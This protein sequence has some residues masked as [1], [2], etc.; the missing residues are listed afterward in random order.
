MKAE[1]LRSAATAETARRAQRT[2]LGARVKI[3]ES[4][5]AGSSGL[6][7]RAAELP[8]G[9]SGTGSVA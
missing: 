6:M 5:L 4:G 8:T 9:H 1:P 3:A 2:Q 7:R